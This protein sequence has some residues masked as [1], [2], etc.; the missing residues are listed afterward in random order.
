MEF[1]I[2]AGI[3]VKATGVVGISIVVVILVGMGPA[4]VL[5]IATLAVLDELDID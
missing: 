2:V 1:R 5:D 3:A 4:V